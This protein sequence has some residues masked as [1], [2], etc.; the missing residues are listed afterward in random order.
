MSNHRLRWQLRKAAVVVVTACSRI[1]PQQR[2]QLMAGRPDA[3]FDAMAAG[4]PVVV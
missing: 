3:F 2:R 4:R 1:A